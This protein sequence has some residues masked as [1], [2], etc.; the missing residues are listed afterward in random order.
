MEKLE[1]FVQSCYWLL[2]VHRWLSVFEQQ[3]VTIQDFQN[4]SIYIFHM[5]MNQVNTASKYIT[6]VQGLLPWAR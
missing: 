6:I 3:L 5:F 4:K 1:S 2:K